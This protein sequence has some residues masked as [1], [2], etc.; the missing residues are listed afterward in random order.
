MIT[1]N[2]LVFKNS[3]NPNHALGKVLFVASP[4]EG[5]CH[6]IDFTTYE[7]RWID[8]SIT[9]ETDTSLMEVKRHGCSCCK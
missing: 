2:S 3:E 4:A 7:V 1:K 9:I 8:G 5:S 6:E